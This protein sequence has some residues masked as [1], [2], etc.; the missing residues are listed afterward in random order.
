[1]S[2]IAIMLCGTFCYLAI[3]DNN[4]QETL[5]NALLIILGTFFTDTKG[6]KENV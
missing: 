2:L 5:K 3:K 6:G 4:Y 1:M